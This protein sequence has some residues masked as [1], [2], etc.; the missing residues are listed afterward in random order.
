MYISQY[1]FSGEDQN[2]KGYWKNEGPE[3]ESAF[4][5]PQIGSE[6]GSD[7]SSVGKERVMFVNKLPQIKK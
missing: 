2:K 1:V 7:A 5:L 6:S 4:K 3:T